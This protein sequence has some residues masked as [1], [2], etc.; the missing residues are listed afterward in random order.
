MLNSKT[1]EY[2]FEIKNGKVTFKNNKEFDIKEDGKIK[3]PKGKYKLYVGDNKLKDESE[4]I[5]ISIQKFITI[6]QEPNSSKVEIKCVHET[7]LNRLA[8][9]SEFNN[10]ENEVRGSNDHIE[11]ENRETEDPNSGSI[12]F[13][14]ALF[15]ILLALNY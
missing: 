6:P 8:E 11:N 1:E 13:G 14:I 5:C 4:N 15:T 3:L 12:E 9:E 2:D 7:F 10:E